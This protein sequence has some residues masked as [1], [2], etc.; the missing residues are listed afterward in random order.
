MKKRIAQAFGLTVS[1]ALCLAA[2]AAAEE[3]LTAE[4]VGTG[5]AVL[6]FLGPE[7]SV[8]VRARMTL[9][10]VLTLGGTVLRFSVDAH[11][12]GS[13]KGNSSTLEAE[14]WVALRGEGATEAGAALTLA[15]GISVDALAPGTSTA[16][17]E[18]TGRFYILLSTAASRWM[19]EG[20]ARGSATGAFVPPAAP[21]TMEVAGEGAFTL[22]GEVRPWSPAPGAN[23]P[24]WPAPLLAE[25]A[26]VAELA[27]AESVKE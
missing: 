23:L 8:D 18:G 21:H 22:I 15:G 16:G 13:G 25:L 5:R 10:G 17:G 20:E 2:H 12:V 9:S 14:G 19:I 6:E 4:A 24:A 7:V 26:R 11:A 1:L 3:G 27:A